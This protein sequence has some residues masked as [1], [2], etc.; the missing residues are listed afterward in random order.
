M[1][2]WQHIVLSL[3]WIPAITDKFWHPPL[4]PLRVSKLLPAMVYKNIR[5]CMHIFH[6]CDL[7]KLLDVSPKKKKVYFGGENSNYWERVGLSSLTFA[8]FHGHYDK[9]VIAITVIK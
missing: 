4:P 1:Y 8:M 6:D 5:M 7:E 3:Q 2:V 9:C